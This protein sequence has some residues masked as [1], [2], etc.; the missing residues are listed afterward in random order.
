MAAKTKL[1]KAVETALTDYMALDEEE[2]LLVLSDKYQRD[3]GYALFYAGQNICGEAFYLEMEPRSEHGEEPPE[4]VSEVMKSVDVVICPTSKSI[5]HTE[6]RRTASNLGI[7]VG[8]MPGVTADSLIRCMSAD[9]KKIIDVTENFYKAVKGADFIQ[10]ETDLGT[11]IH[12]ETKGRKFI[13]ST[14]VMRNIGESGNIPSGEVYLAPV[15][16]TAN[17]VIYFD[18]SIA[19][20]GLL[21]E[22]IKVNIKN[23]YASRISGTKTGKRFSKLMSGV[24]KEARQIAEFGI[25][26]N[27]KATICGD[28]LEDEKV[29]G[30]AHF[31]FGNNIS[32]GGNIN[33]PL[34]LDCIFHKPTVLVNGKVVIKKGELVV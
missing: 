8:T 21:D 25:G 26:T 15:E 3:I 23:G 14:G 20:I 27:Y 32:M 9:Y 16:E 2:T 30:T 17:G 7:R 11:D 12:F 33:V 29:L 24:A 13:K 34:H 5:T 28:V 18:A 6:A 19:G 1:K 4:L 10:V 31:A 22:P